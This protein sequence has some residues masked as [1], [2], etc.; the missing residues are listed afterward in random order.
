MAILL[1]TVNMHLSI[2]FDHEMSLVAVEV[3]DVESLTT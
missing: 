2:N 1:P 3:G